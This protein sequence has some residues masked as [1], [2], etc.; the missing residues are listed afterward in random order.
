ACPVFGASR[1]LPGAAPPQASPLLRTPLPGRGAEDGRLLVAGLGGAA[2]I[3]APDTRQPLEERGRFDPA[4]LAPQRIETFL[5][6]RLLERV[7]SV[8]DAIA[9][10]DQRVA[11]CEGDLGHLVGRRIE[12]AERE[13]A[14]AQHLD[15]ARGSPQ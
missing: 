13:A 8:R 2:T 14:R 5:A 3:L 12:E 1:R 7:L 4:V 9:E 15:A 11:R 10:K 6:E